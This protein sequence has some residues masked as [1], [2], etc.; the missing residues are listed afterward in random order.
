VVRSLQG[1]PVDGAEI[2]V[3]GGPVRARSGPDGQFVLNGLPIGRQVLIFRRIGYRPEALA[4]DVTAD[5]RPLG[6]V[7]MEAGAF[8]LPE[9]TVTARYAKPARYANT[10]KYD[11][12][13]RRR[14]IG[15]GIFLDR[16]L[17]D[18]RF[19]GNTFQMF[20]GLA[21]VYVDVQPPGVGSKLW[22]T[23]CNESPP[24]IGVWVDGVRLLPPWGIGS[25]YGVG[26]GRG[27]VGA[28]PNAAS[29]LADGATADRA[30]DLRSRFVEEVI[31]SVSPADIE[32]IEVYKG[33]SGLPGEFN[34]GDN[35]GAIVIWTREG[36]VRRDP[37]PEN[38]AGR[39][40]NGY[41]R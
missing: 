7:V 10:T 16:D 4:V 5:P 3:Q 22:F 18:Q 39:G 28:T 30:S 41:R 37:A 29:A 23:R 1:E 40:P 17:V 32:A 38:E 26:A 9:I 2:L 36:G 24:A 8:K 34:H 14:K 15:G 20:E 6:P 27:R 19:V 13:Y 33:P 31:N 12:F 21:G 25:G 35:C 11:E